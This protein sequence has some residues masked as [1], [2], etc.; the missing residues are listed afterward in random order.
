MIGDEFTIG[1]NWLM[2]AKRQFQRF[3]ETGDST[4]VIVKAKHDC[5]ETIGGKVTNRSG[6]AFRTRAEALIYSK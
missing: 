1:D 3:L 4:S 6:T 2:S 5:L